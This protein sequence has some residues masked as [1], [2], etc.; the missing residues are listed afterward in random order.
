MTST[1]IKAKNT[2]EIQI[3]KLLIGRVSIF[4]YNQYLRKF[5]HDWYL[6]QSTTF[7]IKFLVLEKATKTL[8]W[9]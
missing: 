5:K 4:V 9:R 8:S 6:F 7:L 3:I 1:I 2:N